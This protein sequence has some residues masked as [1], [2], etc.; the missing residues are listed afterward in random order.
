MRPNGGLHSERSMNFDQQEDLF[1]PDLARPVTV[2]G[3]GSVGSQVVCQLAQVGCRD[4]TVWDG[5]DVA[6]HNIPMSAYRLGDLG[7][8]KVEALADIVQE[9]SGV[10]IKSVNRMWNGENLQG[11]VVCCVDWMDTRLQIWPRVRH[12]PNV[13]IFIDTRIAEEFI[14]VYAINPTDPVHVALY[15]TRL[16]PSSEAKRP[17]CGVHGISYVSG[18]AACAA[19]ARLTSAWKSR[20]FSPLF[21]MLVGSL[22]QIT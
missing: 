5:D 6:S 7:R 22:H 21:E 20:T 15:E 17:M 2:L 16:Y 3:A 10:A 14:A 1:S 11:S 18:V 8:W 9:K 12:N 13:D 19:V 4:I